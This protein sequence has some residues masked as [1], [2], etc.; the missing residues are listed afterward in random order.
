LDEP[1]NVPKIRGIL[2]A[3]CQHREVRAAG[4]QIASAPNAGRGARA[5][6]GIGECLLGQYFYVGMRP[7]NGG[8]NRR[9]SRFF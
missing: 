5:A 6:L 9:G 2:R 3:L 7:N 8:R 1:F 4:D